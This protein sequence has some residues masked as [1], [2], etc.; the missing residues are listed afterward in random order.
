MRCIAFGIALASLFSALGCEP[1]AEP[2]GSNSPTITTPD[3]TPE[4]TPV[5]TTSTGPA[6]TTLPD[7][8]TTP[9]S[10]AVP[11][12]LPPTAVDP[13][14]TPPD[15]TAK[16]AR[17][18]DGDTKT[19]LDQGSSERDTEITAEIRQAVLDLDDASVNARNA[20]I[21]TVNGKVTLRG[22]VEDAQE[23]DAIEQIAVKA[24]GAGNVDNQLEVKTE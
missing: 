11:S 3:A 19:P 13:E 9:S 20:K 23:R 4:T 16:N 12:S 22:P 18:A 1:L 2:P 15:N 8:G 24:A 21:V 7:A 14:P 10:D 5:P 6:T 17:D